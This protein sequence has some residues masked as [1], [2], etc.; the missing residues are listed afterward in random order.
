MAA[1]QTEIPQ[2]IKQLADSSGLGPPV[3]SLR[4]EKTLFHTFAFVT[5]IFVDLVLVALTVLLLL[6]AFFPSIS[7]HP[8]TTDPNKLGGNPVGALVLVLVFGGMAVAAVYYTLYIWRKRR[9]TQ[10]ARYYI[11]RDGLIVEQPGKREVVPW[12][13]VNEV[14]QLLQS[15]SVN[16]IPVGT[17]ARTT[18]HCMDGRKVE[19]SNRTQTARQ[20]STIITR[21]VAEH[22]LPQALSA[23]NN[24]QSLDFGPFSLRIDSLTQKGRENA[25]L[26]W[27]EV[28]KVEVIQ[29]YVF[30]RQAGKRM[31]SWARVRA[32]RI[33]N[34]A[35]FLTLAERMA[36]TN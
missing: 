36:R 15:R 8:A 5:Y 7:S 3:T 16:G 13:E 31:G 21:R 10:T 29:G 6:F 26:S 24:G 33:P 12:R 34:Y 9:E 27:R 30:I 11:F 28:S 25:P 17:W 20:L 2:E 19:I 35:L 18:I 32:S 14:Y 4:H 22:K 1:A 23:L